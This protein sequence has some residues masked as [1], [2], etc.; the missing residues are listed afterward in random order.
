MAHSHKSRSGF[1][2]VELLVVI[3]VIAIL[4][5]LLLPAVQRAREAARRTQCLS[6]LR[7]I[8]LALHN[9]HD[10]H[11]VFPYGMMMGGSVEGSPLAPGMKVGA[12]WQIFILPFIE[13]QALYQRFDVTDTIWNHEPGVSG[14]GG[15]YSVRNAALGDARIALYKCPSDPFDQRYEG[16]HDRAGTVFYQTT[17]NYSGMADSRA[18][19]RPG[20]PLYVETVYDGDGVLYN[21]SS[22][23]LGGITDGTSNTL[24]IGE[25]TNGVVGGGSVTPIGWPWSLSPVVST[26]RGINPPGTVP[27]DGTFLRDADAVWAMSSYH[28]AGA[29]AALADGSARFLSENI[30]QGLLEALAT[31]SGSEPVGE[32]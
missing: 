16:G 8:G 24:L 2:V 12:G 23:S 18:A 13:Q 17:T 5:A 7:Q 30:D 3:G 9:Y 19:H 20:V 29:Q 32:Y 26:G 1:T 27:G 25:V 4:L 28:T 31:R 11:R 14:S 22:V 15:L 6:H 10:Q 21:I